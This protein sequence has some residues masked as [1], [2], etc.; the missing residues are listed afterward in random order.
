MGVYI[1]GMEMPTCC[2]GCC[3]D[4]FCKHWDI[5]P[6][7][8]EDCP[9][10]PVPTPHGRLIDADA[11]VKAIEADVIRKSQAINEYDSGIRAGGR[12]IKQMIKKA[13]TII[14]A[15]EGE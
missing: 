13:P 6:Y 1:K 5:V 4:R 11:I 9:L 2:A 15:E 14:P 3:L 10:V 8:H 12:A 7:R